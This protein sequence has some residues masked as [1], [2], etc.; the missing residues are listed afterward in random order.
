MKKYIREQEKASQYILETNID[1]MSSE[2][3]G[4]VEEKL[5][6]AGVL[7]VYKNSY[8]HEKGRP[9]VKLTV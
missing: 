5:F 6:E 2:L 7:D 3:Y 8:H 1:D 9:A 4:Y